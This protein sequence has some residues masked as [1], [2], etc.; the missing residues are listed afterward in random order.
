MFKI[1]TANLL[2]FFVFLA[3]S[4]KSQSIDH[5]PCVTHS[6]AWAKVVSTESSD[7]NRVIASD[8]EDNVYVSGSFSD[9]MTV[10]DTTFTSN[11]NE[12][13]YLIKYNQA[14]LV[15][16]FKVLGGKGQDEVVAVSPDN[17]GNLYIAGLFTDSLKVEGQQ[18][19]SVGNSADIF[20]AKLNPYGELEWLRSYGGNGYDFPGSLVA[21]PAGALYLTGGFNG[22]ANIGGNVLDSENGGNSF[23]TKISGTGS[24]VW[25]TQFGNTSPLGLKSDLKSNGNIVVGGT[26]SDSLKI[27]NALL[28]HLENDATFL[29]EFSPTGELV[30]AK[31]TTDGRT[32]SLMAAL[33]V[34]NTDA[35]YIGGNFMNSF[36]NDEFRVGD[37]IYF[38][39]G[40]F[41]AKFDD[42]GEATWSHRISDGLFN[43][44]S[45]LESDIGGNV[46]ATG[47]LTGSINFGGTSYAGNGGFLGKYSPDG[48]ELKFWSKGSFGYEYANFITA[49][50]GGNIYWT[51]LFEETASFGENS[52]TVE[53]GYNDA[54][55]ARLNASTP[56]LAFE[57]DT[58]A[59]G[60]SVSALDAF[61]A[62]VTWSSGD[63]LAR[64]VVM[65]KLGKANEGSLEDGK[66]YDDGNGVFGVGSQ[67]A[68]RQFVVY[69]GEGNSAIVT[70]LEPD[71]VYSV[72]VFEYNVDSNCSNSTNYKTDNFNLAYLVTP[73]SNK[74]AGNLRV[75]PNPV[76]S[77]MNIILSTQSRGDTE[78]RLIDQSGNEIH[79]FRTNVREDVTRLSLD[80]SNYNLQPGT[81]YLKINDNYLNQDT[82]R[83][84]KN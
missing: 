22:T 64:L 78:F 68:A 11:G 76:D 15:L 79:R 38:G 73:Q 56:Y 81:Y 21:D 62:E 9:R 23:L 39:T 51:G 14:G 8:G 17:S 24:I 1:F 19:V 5:E 43:Y 34:D 63:G 42:E 4:L 54:F 46:F 75:Y 61:S 45:D 10:T 2:I 67:T 32:A 27:E 3:T 60:V 16:W 33:V 28:L 41:V 70:G 72:T 59:S 83:V 26:F 82:F 50:T 66:I 40:G 69:N 7:G 71:N 80:I 31:K 30:W 48:E 84:V 13:I 36:S 77:Q 35:I 52:V 25:L 12:D 6:W 53:G 20:L 37:S 29:A 49:D 58:K 57:P 18:V 47:L 74:V 55:V 65:K 44:V